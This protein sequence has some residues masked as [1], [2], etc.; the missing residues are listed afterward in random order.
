MPLL[1]SRVLRYRQKSNGET[2]E[3]TLSL[4]Y[5]GGR[6]WK[7]YTVKDENIPYGELEFSSNGTIVEAATRIS[8]TSLESRKTVGAFNQVWV[9]EGADVD[10]VWYDEQTGTETVVAG[11]EQATVP[12]G[13]FDECLKTV[14]TPLPEIADSIKARYERGDTDEQLYLKEKEVVDWQ[15]VR[16]FAAGVG[17][18]KEQIGP[19]GEA[20]IVRELIA[21]E[22]EGA[23]LVDSTQLKSNTEA[24][25]IKPKQ[26]LESQV[27]ESP[28]E[29][30]TDEPQ[31]NE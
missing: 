19:Q 5:I 22:A 14:T 18:V 26:S 4:K 1:D 9:D 12:A 31:T 8:L 3:Y 30:P 7:V 16:W 17:L 23:G 11:F 20:K 13:T 15:T 25:K 2:S 10:S 29:T 21:I 27:E 24:P 6:A 28:E